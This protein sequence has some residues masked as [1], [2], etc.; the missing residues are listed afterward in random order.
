MAGWTEHRS[1]DSRT[2]A[3]LRR[4]SGVVAG[5]DPADPATAAD[6]DEGGSDE[7]PWEDGEPAR[8]H[9]PRSITDRLLPTSLRTGSYDP[10]RAGAVAV[11][12]L[13]LLV[14]AVVGILVWRARPTPRPVGAA[15]APTATA[16][17]ASRG[18]EDRSRDRPGPTSPAVGPAAAIPAT[19]TSPAV[20]VVSVIGKV[21]KPGLLRLPA[22]SR[23]ADALARAGGPLP[24]T[25][26]GL[27]NLAQVL[28]DGSQIAVVVSGGNGSVQAPP[29]TGSGP[30]AGHDAA[31]G[32]AA[33]VDLNTASADQLDALPGVGPSTAQR[34]IAW[35]AA[36][37]GFSSVKQLQQVSGIGPAK[38]AE[39]APKVTV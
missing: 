4:L 1:S 6:H 14:A 34:I 2:V 25:S 21:H 11:V 22:G 19:P 10:S 5:H 17:A 7:Q 38:Y 27:L 26:T 29:A 31:A 9:P 33:P 36:N 16:P 3:R 35:R 39:I 8:R 12:G 15:P 28:T 20:I 18:D 23:V 24:G 37:G 30:G 32:P 13:A